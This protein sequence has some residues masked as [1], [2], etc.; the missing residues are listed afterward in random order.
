[1]KTYKVSNI[2]IQTI[3]VICITVVVYTGFLYACKIM[4]LFYSST[5]VGERFTK[6]FV[7]RTNTILDTL[8][9]ISIRFSIEIILITLV[10]CLAIS[11]V[12]Q[13]FYITRFLY[14]PRGLVGRTV[15]WGLPLTAVVATTVYTLYG[16]A[17]GIAYAIA[18]IPTMCIFS[19]CFELTS[20]TLSVA[21]N[22]FQKNL[23]WGVIKKAGQFKEG[24]RRAC[25]QGIARKEIEA[26][27]QVEETDTTYLEGK[28][29]GKKIVNFPEYQGPERRKFPR[30]RRQL[31]FS[32]VVVSG[33]NRKI[34]SKT[35]LA[36]TKDISL[37]GLSFNTKELIVDGLHISFTT[38]SNGPI[39]IRNRLELQFQLPGFSNNI[40]A[41]GEV[42]WYECVQ[43]GPEPT[44]AVGIK[45]INIGPK[46]KEAIKRY[47]GN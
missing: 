45:F 14:E 10:I 20:R 9:M 34:S 4:W 43:A 11:V 25:L 3:L 36:Q 5:P 24:L 6:V 35:R 7:Q 44:Y 39:P 2:V 33:K 21:R 46:E 13:L 30:V 23:V 27:K 1:M 41:S 42:V 22:L 8:D 38:T 16:G 37:G 29:A 40:T 18:F 32:Y 19:S 12:C 26:N 47:V 15:L 17:W 28:A 31:E